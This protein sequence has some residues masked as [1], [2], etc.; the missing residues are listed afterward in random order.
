M[1][2]EA[3]RDSASECQFGD[4]HMREERPVS[5]RQT[6]RTFVGSFAWANVQYPQAEEAESRWYAK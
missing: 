5:V 4:G 1:K 2:G 3:L 6:G